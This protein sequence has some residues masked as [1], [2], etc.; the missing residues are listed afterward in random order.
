MTENQAVHAPSGMATDIAEIPAVVA[1]VV[2][3]RSAIA[4][5][6][7]AIRAAGPRWATI[8][9]RGS[10]DHVGIYLQYLLATYCGL[11]AGLALPSA[12]TVYGAQLRWQGGLLIA[13]SQ[14][15]ESPDVHSLVEQAR[16]GGA[17]T[18]AIT[19]KPDSP[20][21]HAAERV[22]D[23]MAGEER[24]IPATKTYL[25]CLA[26]AATLIAELAPYGDVAS[27]VR[28]VSGVLE[29]V[30]AESRDWLEGAGSDLLAELT[31]A[32]RALVISRGYNLSTAYETALK[33][34][35]AGGLFASGYSSA[36]VLH[37]PMVVAVPGVP[38]LAFRPDGPIGASVD[39]AIRAAETRGIRPWLVGGAAIDGRAN[40]LALARDLPESLTPLPYALMGQLLSE[41]LAH[42][43]GIIPDAPIGLS[44]VTRTL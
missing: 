15:G 7:A 10:S 21:G 12:T 32:N 23:C 41:R 27:S 16:A 39:D 29:V 35:E 11:P 18:L 22:L 9:A 33:L 28:S 5:S 43:L 6:A 1:R 36:D 20:L 2:E 30:T 24:A 37:G 31:E 17:L 44:K 25:G 40:A 4:A 14:S 38:M 19:N 8:V 13:I 42:R 26:V 34:K 3:E